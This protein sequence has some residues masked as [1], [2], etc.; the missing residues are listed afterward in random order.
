MIHC[1]LIIK[2]KVSKKQLKNECTCN[3]AVTSQVHNDNVNIKFGAKYRK[4]DSTE[5]QR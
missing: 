5:H 4:T 2:A 3:Y 1:Y